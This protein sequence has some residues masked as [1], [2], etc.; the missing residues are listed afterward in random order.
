[1][2]IL[3]NFS[4]A[5]CE[6]G[7]FTRALEAATL[8][9]Q[10]DPTWV[11]GYYRVAMASLG[12]RQPV[13]AKAN[14]TKALRHTKDP[15]VQKLLEEAKQMEMF[16]REKPAILPLSMNSTLVEQLKFQQ[17]IPNW[18]HVKFKDNYYLIDPYGHG[19]FCSISDA[20]HTLHSR[21]IKQFSLIMAPGLYFE[22]CCCNYLESMTPTSIQILGSHPLNSS[23]KSTIKCLS[24]ASTELSLY[25]NKDSQFCLFLFSSGCMVELD[26][27]ELLVDVPSVC[28]VVCED[29]AN[30]CLH[31]CTLKTLSSPCVSVADDK[32]S[33]KIQDCHIKN[34]SA[35]VIAGRRGKVEITD[36]HF[37]ECVKT[38]VEI[39]DGAQGNIS[40]CIFT[41]CHD[42]AIA[43]YQDGNRLN[44]NECIF[45]YCGT[46][47]M[48]GVIHI[49]SGISSFRKCVL[50]ENNGDGL[51]IQEAPF[52]SSASEK[53]PVVFI[54]ECKIKKSPI[55]IGWYY[56]SGVV[57]NCEISSCSMAGIS[58]RNLPI[59][60]KLNICKNKV[61]DNGS[62]AGGTDICVHG[63]SMFDQCMVMN[64]NET[65]KPLM[66]IPDNLVNAF[67]TD[68]THKLETM[69][70]R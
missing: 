61:L 15:N 62:D 11:K 25:R 69:G 21:N 41:R 2:K 37:Q 20:I 50:E 57:S 23:R 28:A 33:V 68:L 40:R 13:T 53:S 5:C 43:L 10:Y 59:S 8:A 66:I 18:E 54:Q 70:V 56:G 45:R 19:H 9:I 47:G 52:S 3:T 42:H 46:R 44:V 17:S 35:G 12:M 49:E 67:M 64:D 34:A 36:T 27:L 51:I 65:S 22:E 26:E 24:S 1:M 14:L 32:C 16:L 7:W 4:A 6:L 38:A 29:E 60:K 63:K 39:R 48:Q 30:V 55:G 58:I 31:H